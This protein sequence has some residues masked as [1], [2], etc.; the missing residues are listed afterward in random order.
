MATMA[1]TTSSSTEV[2]RSQP[3]GLGDRHLGDPLADLGY[4]LNT[5]VGP[6]DEPVDVREPAMSIS[7]FVSRQEVLTRYVE[8]TGADTSNLAYYRAFNLW[9]RAC[10]L[11]GVYARYRSGQK[12][13]EEVRLE[14]LTVRIDQALRVAVD[15][16]AEAF[17]P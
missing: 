3:C 10:I 4:T 15:L 2:V 1:P 17:S 5:W 14:V 9:K 13:A 11:Q 7:G 16:M 12:D 6:A 8:L